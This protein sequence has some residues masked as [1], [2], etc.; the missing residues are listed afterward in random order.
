M[1]TREYKGSWDIDVERYAGWGV[2][3]K[4][5]TLNGKYSNSDK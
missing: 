4:S 3:K 2:K 1:T 5:P